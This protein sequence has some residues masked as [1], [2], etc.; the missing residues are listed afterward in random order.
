MLGQRPGRGA[1]PAPGRVRGLSSPPRSIRSRRGLANAVVRQT[2]AD[3]AESGWRV[4]RRIRVPTPRGVVAFFG[5][6]VLVNTVAWTAGLL[7][8]GLVQRSFEVRSFRNLWGLTASSSRSLVSADDYRTIMTLTSYG[9]GLV[10][11]ILI[12]HLILRLI[13][14]FRCIR[15]ERLQHAGTS[16]PTPG[17]GASGDPYARDPEYCADPEGFGLLAEYLMDD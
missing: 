2:L 10:M 15:L 9:A 6:Q 8:A 3:F 7:A 17:T 5:N 1:F 13:A 16:D 12:R 14:E 4:V 11:L